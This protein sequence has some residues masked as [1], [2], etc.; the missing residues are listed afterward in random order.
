MSPFCFYCL[1]HNLGSLPCMLHG[2][3]VHM[4]YLPPTVVYFLGGRPGSSLIL[5]CRV[6]IVPCMICM[7]AGGCHVVVG[8]AVV[9]HTCAHPCISVPHLLKS[10]LTVCM[11]CLTQVHELVH[12]QC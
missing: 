10:H 2:L 7:D 5:R 9:R 6:M 12:A 4:H 1:K 3:G 11:A 8:H